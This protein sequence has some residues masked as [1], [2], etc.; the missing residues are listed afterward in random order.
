MAEYKINFNDYSFIDEEGSFIAT[1]AHKM[2][3][4]KDNIVAYLD[5]ED[6]QKIVT[7]AYKSADYLGLKDIDIGSTVEAVFETSQSGIVRL[8]EINAI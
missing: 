8:V 4:K 1:L 6:G 7:V 3:G 2:Y 5:L